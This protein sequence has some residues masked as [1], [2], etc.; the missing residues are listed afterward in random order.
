MRT[1]IIITALLTSLF[2]AGAAQAQEPRDFSL[3]ATQTVQ[4]PGTTY[5]IVFNSP[6]LQVGE[7]RDT[8]KL[9]EAIAF[10][11]SANFGMPAMRQIPRVSY[12]DGSKVTDTV[13]YDGRSHTIYL[14]AGWNG[15]SPVELSGFVREM[16]HHLQSET[17]TD[18]QCTP[19]LANAVENRWL[20]M[21]TDAPQ[22]SATGSSPGC[23]FRQSRVEN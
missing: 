9:S 16:V 21:F 23:I 12:G 14:P 7:L 8:A 22:V 13:V 4:L 1:Q 17:G 20:A 15:T 19:N 11:I 2:G 6:E 10:W 5:S 18:Y 3:L